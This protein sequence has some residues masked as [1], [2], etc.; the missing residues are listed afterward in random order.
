MTVDFQ[1]WTPDNKLQFSASACAF[2][3]V[4]TGTVEVTDFYSPDDGTN[5]PA[6][7]QGTFAIVNVNPAADIVITSSP[8]YHFGFIRSPG[9][10]HIQ[11][12]PCY[13][14]GFPPG[15]NGRP[16]YPLFSD[17][18]N[19]DSNTVSWATYRSMRGMTPAAHG[20]GLQLFNEDGSLAYDSTMKPLRTVGGRSFA[21]AD[22]GQTYTIPGT[23]GWGLFTG[24]GI[25]YSGGIGSWFG[26]RA[27][28]NGGSAD[29]QMKMFNFI[30]AGFNLNNGT[31]NC[32]LISAI[33]T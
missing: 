3:L 7:F 9:K 18:T 26:H 1:T 16:G 13:Y 10:L 22:V 4:E 14:M 17:R 32:N 2:A 8:Y 5:N 23:Q 12:Q 30:D 28:L 25:R 19:Q 33:V 27:V 15:Y 29:L 31:V 21:D 6:Y 24:W 11:T 20:V